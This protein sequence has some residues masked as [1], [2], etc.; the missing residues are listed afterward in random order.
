[1]EDLEL[2]NKIENVELEGTGKPPVHYLIRATG[3]V[4]REDYKNP[5]L[6]IKSVTP[7]AEGNLTYFF[8]AEPP[9]G[10]TPGGGVRIEGQRFLFE[11]GKV[12]A[13]TVVAARNE[14]KRSL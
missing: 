1:M 2:V 12:K 9:V 4:L 11:L 5:L 6:I 8:A 7:D 10:G 14:I 3:S 13:I